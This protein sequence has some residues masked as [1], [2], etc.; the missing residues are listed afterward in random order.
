MGG[1]S[2][3]L[4]SWDRALCCTLERVLSKGAQALWAPDPLLGEVTISPELFLLA[5]SVSPELFP[6]PLLS[7]YLNLFSDSSSIS[8][9]GGDLKKD[10]NLQGYFCL[11]VLIFPFFIT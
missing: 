2:C 10:S 3:V 1:V 5:F 9:G 8:F 11:F 7:S 4:C 6:S